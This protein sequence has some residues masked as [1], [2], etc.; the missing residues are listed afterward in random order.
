[1]KWNGEYLSMRRLLVFILFMLVNFLF[2][3]LSTNIPD[4]KTGDSGTAISKS[5]GSFSLPDD[6]VEL[7]RYSRNGKYFYSHQSEADN[8]IMT[9][10]SIELGRNPYALDDHMTF[11]YAILRQLLM[12]AG[13]AQVSGSGTYTKHDDPLYIFVIESKEDNVTTTQFYIVGNKKHILIHL[14]DF[15]NENI[16]N[17]EEIAR[18]MAD[19]FI[20]AK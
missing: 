17:A 14:T 8:S 6:W 4:G 11:R 10:I 19:S 2:S 3:C 9:N 7:T 12:Q 1:M 15:H 13:N 5:F 16:T 20:W 18:M